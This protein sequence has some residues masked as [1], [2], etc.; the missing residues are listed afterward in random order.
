MKKHKVT[1]VLRGFGEKSIITT[2]WPLTILDTW[3]MKSGS[4]IG[5]EYSLVCEGLKKRG[6]KYYFSGFKIG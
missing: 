1:L 2:G 5:V 3:I 6:W 4:M